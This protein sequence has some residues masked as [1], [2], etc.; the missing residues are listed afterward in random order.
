MKKIVLLGDSIREGYDKYV[1][2]A[3]DGVAQVYYPK[4]NCRFTTYI[5]R[6]LLDWKNNLEW[7]DDV[8][9]VHWNV[10]LWDDIRMDD[11]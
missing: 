2:L 3:F 6:N 4:E 9:L 1:K 8:A 11:G 10:G 7:G 5:I